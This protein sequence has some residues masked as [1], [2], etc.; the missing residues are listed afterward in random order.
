MTQQLDPTYRLI[1]IQ[2]HVDR[3]T[4]YVRSLVY[5]TEGA[6]AGMFQVFCAD[7]LNRFERLSREV[8]ELRAEIAKA[9]GSQGL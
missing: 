4:L 7:I 5:L 2:D 6:T 9:S 3:E 8:S 1:E